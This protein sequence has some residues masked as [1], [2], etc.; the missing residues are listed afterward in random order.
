MNF[1]ALFAKEVDIRL[2]G[3]RSAFV[4]TTRY[5]TLHWKSLVYEVGRRPKIDRIDQRGPQA[6]V[7]LEPPEDP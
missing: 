4:C 2:T 6:G 5:G 3:D 1:C 7:S